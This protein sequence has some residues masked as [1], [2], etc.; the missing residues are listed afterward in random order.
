M[1]EIVICG[2]SYE[3]TN[4]PKHG[5]VR[6]I[7]KERQSGIKKFMVMF[8]DGIDMNGDV[9]KEVQR[10]MKEHPNEAVDFGIEEA[11]FLARAT[12][13]LATNH[14][15]GEEDFDDLTEKQIETIFNTCKE[16]LGGDVNDFF[17]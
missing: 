4:E 14:Y 10:L 12:I 15:F 7:R 9:D 5:I 2:K 8:K 1:S 16:S 3:L 6:K 17:A 13:S 11:E